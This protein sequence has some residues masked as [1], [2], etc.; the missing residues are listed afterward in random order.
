M[1]CNLHF[2]MNKRTHHSFQHSICRLLQST[3]Q[4]FSTGFYP[5]KNT[6]QSVS[7]Q[8]LKNARKSLNVYKTMVQH[9]YISCIMMAQQ[10]SITNTCTCALP[11][12]HLIHHY[13]HYT[14]H[15]VSLANAQTYTCKT[16]VLLQHQQNSC[17]TLITILYNFQLSSLIS[18][19]RR[20]KSKKQK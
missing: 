11:C 10:L 18:K 17:F 15:T 8:K 7:Y 16:T 6:N 9:K 19:I 12:D 20:P 13:S 5:I 3:N 4:S 1:H 14:L 2:V